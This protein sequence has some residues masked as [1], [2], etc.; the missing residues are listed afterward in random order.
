MRKVYYNPTT[1]GLSIAVAFLIG[2]IELVG[3]LHDQL[4]LNDPIT[5]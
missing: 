2:T 1:T 4:S 5:K 3:I